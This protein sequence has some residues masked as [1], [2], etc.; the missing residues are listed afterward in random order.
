[1][2][3]KAIGA[4][5]FGLGN[6]NDHDRIV[7]TNLYVIYRT[8]KQ[9][10]KKSDDKY[11]NVWHGLQICC[12]HDIWF[13]IFILL[14]LNTVYDF[15]SSTCIWFEG[16]FYLKTKHNIILKCK[17]IMFVYVHQV[18]KEYKWSSL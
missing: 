8:N 11:L 14:S 18:N 16:Y 12:M 3:H 2:C 7:G 9:T 10:N 1:M 15:A 6:G 4:L 5:F 17:I 13:S